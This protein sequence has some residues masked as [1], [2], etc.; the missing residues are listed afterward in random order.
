MN[1]LEAAKKADEQITAIHKAFGA[2]GD[3]GYEKREGKALYEL[4]KF[5][6]ELRAAIAGMPPFEHSRNGPGWQRSCDHLLY[7]PAAEFMAKGKDW[8]TTELI[9]RKLQAFDNLADAWRAV[10]SHEGI[11][12]RASGDDAARVWNELCELFEARTQPLTSPQD[13]AAS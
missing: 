10:S 4:Y 13:G 12:I 9:R 5:Q 11:D 6:T 7:G 2:P 8:T 3:W 1:P